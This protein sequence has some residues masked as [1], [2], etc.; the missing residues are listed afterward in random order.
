MTKATINNNIRIEKDSL[1]KKE[2]PADAYY[3]IQSLRAVENFP[4][5]GIKTHP[6]LIR[7]Y[8]SIK[9]A[10]ALANKELKVLAADKADAIVKAADEVLA[11]KWDCQFIIDVYQAGA[12]TSF[13]MNSNEV[14]A[15]R[16]SE[17]LGGKLGE[18]KLVHPNDH[19]N[20]AQSTNDTFPTAAHIALLSQIRKLDGV[21]SSLAEAFFAKGKEFWGVIKSARTH[22]QDA[23]PITLGQ[24]FK[25]YGEAVEACRQELERRSQLLRRV[26]L[27]VTA[28]GTGTNTAPKFREKA[29]AHLAE[30]TGLAL[31]PARDPRMGLQSHQPLA[32]S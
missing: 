21:L 30:I 31:E 9:K 16:A 20:M 5:S 28:A 2:V 7:A 4:I 14:I 17:L 10:C 3:G 27:G 15:N 11:G 26:A 19:V 13:N 23:V 8:A 25:A 18:Y 12:G 1:G 24:E 32:A 22:L 29:I 6:S